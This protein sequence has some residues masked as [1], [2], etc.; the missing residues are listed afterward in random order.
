MQRIHKFLSFLLAILMVISIVP[1]TASA[2]T[3]S[4]TCGDNL[5]WTLDDAGVLTISGT[6]PMYD[7]TWGDDNIWRDMYY[8]QIGTI[9]INDGVTT[10]GDLAFYGLKNL[11]SV[12][13][14]DT[15]T[16]IGYYAL[17]D[18]DSLKSI[19][20]PDSVTYID[21]DAFCHCKITSITIPGSVVTIGKSAFT[22]CEKMTSL[23]LCDVFVVSIT[24][25]RIWVVRPVQLT[26]TPTVGSWALLQRWYPVF[27]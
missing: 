21:D 17:A 3:R 19:I 15:V 16:S 7:H 27:G 25:R 23:T 9:V 14:P 2:E 6:G 12:S 10:I 22:G 13:I 24:S 4:G 26:I 1:L 5:T 18:C 20:I 11:V 8:D